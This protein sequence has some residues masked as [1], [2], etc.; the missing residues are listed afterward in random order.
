MR[1]RGFV[2]IYA[3]GG[4]EEYRYR[5]EA[6]EMARDAWKSRHWKSKKASDISVF[7]SL[8]PYAFMYETRHLVAV[9]ADVLGPG[10]RRDWWYR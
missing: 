3:D 8:R 2:C 9:L 7:S 10:V 1:G 6:G 5:V 4:T